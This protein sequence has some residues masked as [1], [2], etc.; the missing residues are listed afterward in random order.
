MS[1]VSDLS[2][3]HSKVS[4]HETNS[5]IVQRRPAYCTCNVVFKWFR[6]ERKKSSIHPSKPILW[7]IL[8]GHPGK[9]E[10]CFIFFS[11]LWNY[12]HL[13]T[14]SRRNGF[15]TLSR[16]MGVNDCFVLC[17]SVFEILQ[18]SLMLSDIYYLVDLLIIR[19]WK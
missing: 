12:I 11:V 6:N 5:D 1:S 17:G 9:V 10:K 15:V 4:H 18:P 19:A 14:Q 3:S 7:F 16:M 2:L 13:E 8:V